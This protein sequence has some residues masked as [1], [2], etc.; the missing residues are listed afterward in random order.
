MS[1][2]RAF[3]QENLEAIGAT[4][5]GQ[6]MSSAD[7]NRSLSVLTN[8]IKSWNIQGLLIHAVTRES[9][10]LTANDGAYTHGITTGDI[11]TA[12]PIRVLEA[13]I[14]SGNVEYPLRIINH[15]E[16]SEIVDKT[17]T[18][19]IPS[20]LYIEG[21][22][23]LETYNLYPIPSVA[24]TLIIQSLKPIVSTLTLDT[25]LSMP[26]GYE[27]ALG[28]NFRV[29]IAPFFSKQ[30]D[31]LTLQEAID[32]KANIMRQNQKEVLMVSD[33]CPVGRMYNIMTGGYE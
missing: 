14:K 26:D 13:A 29:V 28:Y 16:Y 22:Y 3:L 15:T 33:L 7:A 17:L 10:V 6:T 8:L 1:T 19:E 20:A 30:V 27:W 12:R 18:S 5:A 21:T 31:Q 2:I 9:Y 11:A 24:N 23:P 4:G 25:S 32:S